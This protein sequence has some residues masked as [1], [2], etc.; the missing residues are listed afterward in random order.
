M[1][2]ASDIELGGIAHFLCA[3]SL[4]RAPLASQGLAAR[5]RQHGL[6][7]SRIYASSCPAERTTETG[8]G[9]YSSLQRMRYAIVARK[10][11]RSGIGTRSAFGVTV[12]CPMRVYRYNV[13]L[14]HYKYTLTVLLLLQY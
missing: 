1:S 2:V 8:P 13:L 9:E 10:P 7:K 4:F 12:Q 6:G 5:S 3:S 11:L 14:V